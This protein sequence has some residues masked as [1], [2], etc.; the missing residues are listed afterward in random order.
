MRSALVLLCS[1]SMAAGA[2]AQQSQT[3]LGWS[4]LPAFNYD[5]DEGFGYGVTGG[6]YQYGDGR[7]G[8]YVWAL[9]PTVF[10]TSHGHNSVSIFYDAPEQFGHGL[11]MTARLNIDR[12]C[13]QPYYGL[14]NAAPYDTALVNR[15]SL[16]NYY[17]YERDR[18]AVAADLQWSVV[19]HLRVL[20]GVAAQRNTATSRDSST[21][22]AEN[23]ANGTVAAGEGRSTVLGP[24]VGVVYDSRD[25]ER[26][27]RRG[28]WMEGLAWEGLALGSGD[29]FTRLTATLRGY[30]SPAPWLTFAARVLAEHVRGDMPLTLLADIGS[31]YQDFTGVGG[32][33]SVR[34]VLRLRYLGRTRALSNLEVR[35]R[36]PRFRLLGAPWQVGAVGF[37]DAGRVWDSRGFGDGASGLHWGRGAGLRLAWGQSFIIAADFAYGAEAGLQTYL[38]LGQLF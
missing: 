12:D 13:C 31:S 7:R 28:V 17:S 22:F 34:G 26:D 29:E 8:P 33:E 18:L 9:E 19:R 20:T 37:V 24:R 14:G 1:C 6:L 23:V 25:F 2:V 11:R 3:G 21:L 35:W 30:V 38:R 16:P 15:P 5:S 27:P 4:G 36:G 32:A 10:F